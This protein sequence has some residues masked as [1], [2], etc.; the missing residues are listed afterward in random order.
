MQPLHV[1]REVVRNS[2]ELRTVTPQDV[3]QWDAA[4]A[5]FE[6]LVK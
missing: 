4:F 6:K 3:A 5:R 1:S 2:F